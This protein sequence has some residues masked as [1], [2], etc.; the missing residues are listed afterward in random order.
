VYKSVS[1]NAMNLRFYGKGAKIVCDTDTAAGTFIGAG[2]GFGLDGGNVTFEDLEFI[3]PVATLNSTTKGEGHLIKIIGDNSSVRNCKFTGGN[4]AAIYMGGNYCNIDANFL[5]RCNFLPSAGQYFGA[6]H[7]TN[8][9]KY[10]SI[11]N[12]KMIDQFYAGISAADES[13]TTEISF[14]TITNNYIRSN[15]SSVANNRS[16]GIWLHAG[17]NR[18]VTVANNII[19][20]IDVEGIRFMSGVN[21]TAENCII[22]GNIMTDCDS[23]GVS[24]ES[25]S[26]PGTFTN[27]V[28]T[29][30]QVT[31]SAAA[32]SAVNQI[33]VDKAVDCVIANNRCAAYKQA[34]PASAGIKFNNGCPRTVVTNN[35]VSGGLY[36]IVFYSPNGLLAQNL[37]SDCTT[38]LIIAFCRGASVQ[39]NVIKSC[40]TGIDTGSDAAVQLSGNSILDCTHHYNT[41]G[42]VRAETLTHTGNATDTGYSNYVVKGQLSGGTATVTFYHVYPE[43][44]FMVIPVNG[45][46]DIQGVLYVSATNTTS[47]TVKVRSTLSTDSRQFMLVKMFSGG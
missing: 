40:G 19:E 7:V 9:S 30:N 31:N 46:T 3:A 39:G 13:Q 16:R 21:F 26:T 6:I 20:K 34:T 11:T 43:D 1:G 44:K 17:A 45:T 4:G 41:T 2:G 23:R 22:S 18:N 38:G 10:I 47:S 29:N 5:D 35:N 27:F 33:W 42:T 37:V 36:G 32:P 8:P 24:L 25:L 28:I 14:L 15:S 12:N